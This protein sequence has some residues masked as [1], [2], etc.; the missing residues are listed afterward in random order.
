MALEGHGVA[1]LPRSA[2]KKEVQAGAL[3][4][5][6]LPEG[7]A[8]ALNMEVRAYREKPFSQPTTPSP[9]HMLWQHLTQSTGPIHSSR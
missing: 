3:V 7:Q 2:V 5:V 8:L 1:F 9:A 6:T 4:E